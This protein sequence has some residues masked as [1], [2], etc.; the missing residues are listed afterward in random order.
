VGGGDRKDATLF[1]SIVRVI[2]GFDDS[3]CRANRFHIPGVTLP[4]TT[5]GKQPNIGISP[6]SD[7]VPRLLTSAKVTRKATLFNR[8]FKRK[9]PSEFDSSKLL[10][11]KTSNLTKHK[12]DESHNSRETQTINGVTET[13]RHVGTLNN[14]SYNPLLTYLLSKKWAVLE[15]PKKH[16]R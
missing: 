12:L 10:Q 7:D 13:D 4:S 16:K 11:T 6:C 2:D 15:Q 8:V 1:T 5:P 14:F 3:I 9:I